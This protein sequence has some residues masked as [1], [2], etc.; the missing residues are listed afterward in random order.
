MI[1]FSAADIQNPLAPLG[2]EQTE[3]RSI[4][5]FI[6]RLTLGGLVPGLKELGR[7]YIE[8]VSHYEN[9]KGLLGCSNDLVKSLPGM[10]HKD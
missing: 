5:Q 7:R 10:S 3:N 9:R 1:S 2:I 6:Y 8:D 4:D